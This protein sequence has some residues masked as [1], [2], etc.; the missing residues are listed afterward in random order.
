MTETAAAVALSTLLLPELEAE[1]KRTRRILDALPEDQPEFKPHEKSKA[2]AKLAGHTA[3]IPALGWLILT[4]PGIDMAAPG[5]PRKTVVMESKEQ[6]LAEFDFNATRLLDTLKQASE[7]SFHEPW[8]LARG[9]FKIF[10]GLRYDA[11]RTFCLNHMIHHRAQ[12][13]CYIRDLNLTLPGTYGPSA[14]GM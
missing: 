10:S 13:G 11:Y 2:L 4:T 1:L 7:E 5:N 9:E 3:E 8:S 12:L 14:D 6:L